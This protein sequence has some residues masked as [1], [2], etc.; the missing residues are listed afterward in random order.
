[1]E[2]VLADGTTVQLGGRI[3]GTSELS[4]R[5]RRDLARRDTVWVGVGEHR[6]RLDPLQPDS[7]AYWLVD[8]AWEYGT[9]VLAGHMPPPRPAPPPGSVY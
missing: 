4:A 7:V 9:H 5:L 6:A 1:M 8:R 2:W 3:S